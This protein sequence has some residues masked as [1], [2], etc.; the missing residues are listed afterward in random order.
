MDERKKAQK[1]EIILSPPPP[2]FLFRG[3]SC[4]TTKK[5]SSFTQKR[6]RS[7]AA[8][9]WKG[10]VERLNNS[11]MLS[12]KKSTG[13][14]VKAPL[15]TVCLKLT[16]PDGSVRRISC[17]QDEATLEAVRRYVLEVTH[18]PLET[19]SFHDNDGDECVV[20]TQTD[21]AEACR[22][23]GAEV[24]A[25]VRLTVKTAGSAAA[26][27]VPQE[28]SPPFCIGAAVGA[29]VCMYVNG[30]KITFSGV[31]P[32]TPLVSAIRDYTRFTGTKLSCGEG[33]C[34][35]CVVVLSSAAPSATQRFDGQSI[36]EAS[37]EHAQVNSC[38]RPIF[39]CDGMSVT[40]SEGIGSFSA[41]YHEVQTKLADGNGSQCGYCSPGFVMSMYGLLA[42][43]DPKTLTKE[44][45]EHNLDGNICRCTGYRPIL[46]A[47]QQFAAPSVDSSDEGSSVGHQALARLLHGQKVKAS[48][49]RIQLLRKQLLE[50]FRRDPEFFLST[51]TV[52]MHASPAKRSLSALPAAGSWVAPTTLADLQTLLGQLATQTTVGYELVGAHTGIGGVYQSLKLPDESRSTVRVSLQQVAEFQTFTLNSTGPADNLTVGANVT[53][54]ALITKLTSFIGSTNVAVDKFGTA[55][56]MMKRIASQPVRNVAT[57]AGNLAMVRRHGFASDLATALVGVS[58]KVQVWDPTSASTDLVT[59]D[60]MDFLTPASRENDAAAVP[61]M[62]LANLVLT[63]P[64]S[65]VATEAAAG[66]QDGYAYFKVAVRPQN[67]HSLVNAFIG[68][69]VSTAAYAGG[70]SK[71][72]G[73]D[74]TYSATDAAP[75]LSNVRIVYGAIASKPLLASKTMAVLEGSPLDG[76]NLAA[77]LTALEGELSDAVVPEPAYATADNPKGKLAARQAVLAPFLYKWCVSRVAYSS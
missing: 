62:L 28:Q 60:L 38:L 8:V 7:V 36:P 52:A 40:T 26:D 15:L 49:Q 76:A 51:R 2:V 65:A 66:T 73:P 35:A 21:F 68:A 58:A 47:F 54:A 64:A 27:F 50:P 13:G 20:T 53:I 18:Q 43:S 77:A 3:S 29:D 37:I 42:N 45:I 24:G 12:N 57:W 61:E 41:G 34:G 17:P 63:V 69:Q 4:S 71:K 6:V 5:S 46:E 31:D 44:D 74:G 19:L 72:N 48:H 25:V 75:T 56:S 10:R 67:A 22:L 16:L 55:V 70:G 1:P 23:A 59:Q 39:L 9:A 30:E 33:G 32:S 11:P 14:A